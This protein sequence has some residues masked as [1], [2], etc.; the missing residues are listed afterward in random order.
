MTGE[1]LAVIGSKPDSFLT[2]GLTPTKIRCFVFP[3]PAL[4]LIGQMSAELLTNLM[5][6][7]CV[8]LL[9][10]LPCPDKVVIQDHNKIRKRKRYSQQ[11]GG[12]SQ[13]IMQTVLPQQ[14]KMLAGQTVSSLL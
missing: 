11:N 5:F 10:H 2:A 9:P 14:S 8:A 12:F 13:E 3:T 4:T 7:S 1:Y 6:S